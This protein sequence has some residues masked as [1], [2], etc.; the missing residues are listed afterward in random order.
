MNSPRRY[1][2][3]SDLALSFWVKLARVYWTFAHHSHKDIGRYA[4]TPPQFAVLE[5]LGHL[6]SLTLGDLSKKRLVTGGCMTL[7]VDNLEKEGLVERNRCTEDRRIIHV[8][9]TA[10]GTRVFRTVFPPHAQRI[11]ELASV[12]SEK[13]QIQLSVLL[14]KLGLKLVEREANRDRA[15]VAGRKPSL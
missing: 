11:T 8:Q 7:V 12:L 2:K 1:G 6:G 4:L 3:Q 13:E 14:K 9:L 5:A 15:P 10:K